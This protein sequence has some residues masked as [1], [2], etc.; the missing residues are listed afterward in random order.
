MFKDMDKD[1]DGVISKDEFCRVCQ[2]HPE[3]TKYF[4]V[5]NTELVGT[6][7]G[8]AILAAAFDKLD[9]T[10]SGEVNFEELWHFMRHEMHTQ[11]PTHS[12][13]AGHREARPIPEAVKL[14]VEP[15]SVGNGMKLTSWE[16]PEV[17]YESQMSPR[18]CKV[19]AGFGDR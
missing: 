5:V 10:E 19:S 1:N 18:R 11:M 3:Y 8:P 2:L 9:H 14:L 15:E 17:G 6:S 7:E 13:V 12:N 16:I 4:G